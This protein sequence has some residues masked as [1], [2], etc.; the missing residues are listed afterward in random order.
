M[1]IDYRVLPSTDEL[2]SVLQEILAQ[3]GIAS[4]DRSTEL[5]DLGLDSLTTAEV[6]LRVRGRFVDDDRDIDIPDDFLSFVTVGD[7]IDTLVYL[8]QPEGAEG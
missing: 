2:L 5:V 6:I 4:V 3:R 1:T 7:V 8:V